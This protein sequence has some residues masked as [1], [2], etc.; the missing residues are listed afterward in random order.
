MPRIWPVIA[1]LMILGLSIA[2]D[3][4]Q[5]SFGND[6][7]PKEKIILH[8]AISSD[9]GWLVPSATR[10]KRQANPNSDYC[11]KQKKTCIAKCTA[12]NLPTHTPSGDPFFKC[13][14]DCM[15]EA[16]CRA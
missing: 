4:G 7:Q 5:R 12:E 15:R 13:L 8:V 16:G 9:E 3:A 2:C 1:A 11:Q 14:A 6:E 10:K